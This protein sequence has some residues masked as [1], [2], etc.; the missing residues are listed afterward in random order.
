MR[1]SL[2]R[3]QPVAPLDWGD[4]RA[5]RAAA[6]ERGLLLVDLSRCRDAIEA[7][8]VIAAYA[9]QEGLGEQAVRRLWRF[10]RS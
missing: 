7:G 6:A 9:H 2:A 10:G 3:Q 8:A 4:M 1:T 5:M